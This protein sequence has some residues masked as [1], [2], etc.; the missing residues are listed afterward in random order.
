MQPRSLP[1]AT[2]APARPARTF[3]GSTTRSIRDCLMIMSGSRSPSRKRRITVLDLM[4]LVIGVSLALSLN[5]A[6]HA[7]APPGVM[8]WRP[9]KLA[10]IGEVLRPIEEFVIVAATLPLLL[11]RLRQPRP[12]LAAPGGSARRASDYGL[13]CMLALRRGQW[14]A[15]GRGR[16]LMV[17][18]DQRVL[19][20][21]VCRGSLCRQ[22]WLII[23]ISG[24][25][26]RGDWVDVLAQITGGV[27][28]VCTILSM[29]LGPWFP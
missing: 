5:R 6:E 26:R 27:L 22:P 3:V 15:G 16:W 4:A 13:I 21:H 23:L 25:W 20:R 9:S 19:G 7:E 18:V 24:R 29:T 28:L 12:G 11:L 8:T 10:R 14:P 17:V 2:A 1:V